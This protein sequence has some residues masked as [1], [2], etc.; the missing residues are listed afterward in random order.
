MPHR[1]VDVN[2]LMLTALSIRMLMDLYVEVK[3]QTP[4]DPLTPGDLSLTYHGNKYVS[5]LA[6]QMFIAKLISNSFCEEKSSLT[7]A[8]KSIR[9]IFRIR[10][11]T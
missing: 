11:F 9:V 6:P 4:S 8:K 3:C 1:A 5:Q 10:M 2:L 7:S